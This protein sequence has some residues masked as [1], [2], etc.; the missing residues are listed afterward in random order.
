MTKTKNQRRA[1]SRIVSTILA[2]L[3]EAQQRLHDAEATVALEKARVADIQAILDDAEKN[4][5]R[6]EAK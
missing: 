5:P 4:L 3:V 2:R 6:A 1:F